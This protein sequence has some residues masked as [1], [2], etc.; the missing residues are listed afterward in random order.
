MRTGNSILPEYTR[1]TEHRPYQSAKRSS[2]L[3]EENAAN[4]SGTL[5]NL[6]TVSGDVAELL[7]TE[8]EHLQSAVR[9]LSAFAD[10]LG[11]NAPRVDSIVGSLNEVTAQLAEADFA[12]RLSQSVATLDNLLGKINAG[13]G[14]LGMLLND[15]ALYDSL[16]VASGNLASLLADLERYPGRYV[17]FS[18]FGR[19]PEKMKTKADRRAAREAEKQLKDSLR[20]V[21]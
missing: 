3:L 2:P 1:R 19:D 8:K 12:Q 14:S 6:N 16:T 7:D 20:R 10:M 13:E 17:H 9:N 5:G 21:R 15:R 11:E 18:L 4:L